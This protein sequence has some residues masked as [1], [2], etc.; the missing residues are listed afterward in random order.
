MKTRRNRRPRRRT[1]GGYKQ[2]MSNVG[3]STGYSSEFDR[4]L[5]TPSATR[6]TTNWV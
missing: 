2:Y 3:F 1:R 4:N 5:T 6:M